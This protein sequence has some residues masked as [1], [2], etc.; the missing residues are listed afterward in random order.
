MP[1]FWG[2]KVGLFRCAVK[3]A[4]Y[5]FSNKTGRISW[6]EMIT[7][8]CQLEARQKFNYHTSY[9]TRVGNY[10]TYFF[11]FDTTCIAYNHQSLVWTFV[12]CDW[13]VTGTTPSISLSLKVVI[14]R[15][16]K[17]G[18][19]CQL[20]LYLAT[21]MARFCWDALQFGQI[22]IFLKSCPRECLH[23]LLIEA[24]AN[25]FRVFGWRFMRGSPC[26]V[27]VGGIVGG[28]FSWWKMVSQNP[29]N[30]TAGHSIL[31]IIGG[32]DRHQFEK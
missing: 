22:W 2:A 17:T 19:Q 23:C 4:N 14:K 28:C 3:V 18:W 31:W 20:W 15:S 27:L 8:S 32:D 12:F 9:Y 5:F 7:T 30:S 16:P 25:K 13:H 24:N 11:N 26:F 10:T 29:W 1:I 21:K 6:Q